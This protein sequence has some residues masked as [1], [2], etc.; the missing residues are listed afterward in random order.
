MNIEFTSQERVLYR[1]EYEFAI[2]VRKVT[3][4]E[5]REQAMNKILEGRSLV[6]KLRKL[7]WTKR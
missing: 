6:K 3:E 5:A 1:M 7:G 4:V 2:N